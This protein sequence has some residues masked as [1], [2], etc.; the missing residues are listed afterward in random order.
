MVLRSLSCGK[1]SPDSNDSIFKNFR[2]DTWVTFCRNK[3][4][5]I[6]LVIICNGVIGIRYAENQK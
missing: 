4:I 6:H 3:D 1:I 2:K 5:G